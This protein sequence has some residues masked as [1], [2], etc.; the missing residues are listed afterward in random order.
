M[1]V[2]IGITGNSEG[3]SSNASSSDFGGFGVKPP[4][5][6]ISQDYCKA[7]ILAGAIPVFIPPVAEDL[8]PGMVASLDGILFSG[9]VDINPKEY[10]E[11]HHPLLGDLDMERDSFEL[12][13]FRH[14]WHQ[15]SLPVL[16]VCRGLQ[17]INVAL[18][19]TLWQDLPSQRPSHVHHSQRDHRYKAVHPMKVD[20]D[21]KLGAILPKVIAVN[22]LHHQGV[23]DLGEGL[24]AC[25]WSPDGLVEGIEALDHPARMAVQWHPENLAASYPEF[26]GLFQHFV[27]HA[28]LAYQARMARLG[29]PA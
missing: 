21:S 11:S 8:V 25:A 10:N 24:K 13:L 23:K 6:L 20:P 4:L 15:T 28:K 27:D 22:S 26:M 14:V 2:F 18:G 5:Y 16:G 3:M 19:G 9:G 1:A 7:V 17:L 12:A 29:V